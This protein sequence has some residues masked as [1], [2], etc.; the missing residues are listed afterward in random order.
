MSSDCENKMDNNELGEAADSMEQ[1]TRELLAIKNNYELTFSKIDEV[2]A[3]PHLPMDMDCRQL[4]NYNRAR[5]KYEE[6]YQVIAKIILDILNTDLDNAW[7][8]DKQLSAQYNVP[9][10]AAQRIELFHHV[11]DKI[12]LIIAAINHRDMQIQK[13]G[14]DEYEELPLESKM[15]DSNF[16]KSVK[17]AI[18]AVR[19]MLE[20]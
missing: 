11:R 6:A 7:S 10:E 16:P 9:L 18:G 20:G 2:K 17:K 3:F 15:K 1:Y 8:D 4:Q 14:V 12:D 5:K 19:K 13:I